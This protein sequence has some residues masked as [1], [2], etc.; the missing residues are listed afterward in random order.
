M[1][2]LDT[3]VNFFTSSCSFP[4]LK[5]T[6]L[7]S[8]WLTAQLD[9]QTKETELKKSLNRLT[10]PGALMGRESYLGAT[11]NFWV[12]DHYSKNTQNKAK[13]ERHQQTKAFVFL[14][15]REIPKS[16]VELVNS[17]YDHI[18]IIFQKKNALFDSVVERRKR[19]EHEHNGWFVS[20]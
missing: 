18:K 5:V 1:W 6:K 7:N 2:W 10:L 14:R 13:A 3:D 4:L 11:E 9:G 15:Q 17:I 12:I 8:D 20:L 16:S 19:G